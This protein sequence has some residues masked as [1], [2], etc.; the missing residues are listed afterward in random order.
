MT[1]FTVD[2]VNVYFAELATDSIRSVPVSGGSSVLVAS[3]VSGWVLANDADELYWLDLALESP[4]GMVKTD[5]PMDWINIPIS[6]S[7]DPFVAYEALFLDQ[8]GFY[9]SETQTGSIYRIH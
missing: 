2:G 1:D 8:T 4:A 5:S 3:N 7:F 6:L 9:I